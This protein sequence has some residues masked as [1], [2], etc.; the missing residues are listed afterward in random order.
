[1]QALYMFIQSLLA[2]LPSI[3]ILFGFSLFSMLS[4]YVF[5]YVAGTLNLR[6]VRT[7]YTRKIVHVAI[8]CSVALV[9][10]VLG[11]MYVLMFGGSITLVILCAIWMGDGNILYESIARESDAPHRTHLIIIPI[12]ATVAGGIFTNTLFG[13]IAIFGY[14]VAGIGD[15]LGEPVGV[16]F[17]KHKI[18]K[19]SL[20]TI[21]GSIGVFI[22]SLSALLIGQLIT[23]IAIPWTSIIILA[24]LVTIVEVVSPRGMDNLFMQ[25]IPV[26]IIFTFF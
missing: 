21:E 11:Y 13:E 9:Q 15:A 25:I 24:V 4:G 10:A 17:G 2:G 14:L 6:G 3:E 7:G 19:T 26:W 8:F 5:L 23:S 16:R 18:S 20:K 1:M 12:I 22:G